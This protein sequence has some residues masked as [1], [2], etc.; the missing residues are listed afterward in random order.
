VNVYSGVDSGTPQHLARVQSEL[1]YRKATLRLYPT[2]KSQ[3]RFLR[4]RIAELREAFVRDVANLIRQRS[5]LPFRILR[6]QLVTDP[7][8]LLATVAVLRRRLSSP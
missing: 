1:R 7:S 6:E 5:P 3:Q 8:T 2:T 4:E